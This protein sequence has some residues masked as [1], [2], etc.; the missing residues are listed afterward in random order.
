MCVS[1]GTSHVDDHA[2][3]INSTFCEE[4]ASSED[5]KK[6]VEMMLDLWTSYADFEHM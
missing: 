1:A 6:F 4:F 3:L 5:D 2:Y